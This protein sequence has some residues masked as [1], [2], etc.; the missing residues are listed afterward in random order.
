MTQIEQQ[1][2]NKKK[3]SLVSRLQK[4]SS[5]VPK[6]FCTQN[7][8]NC[9]VQN[10]QDRKY[11]INYECLRLEQEIGLR[12][13]EPTEV[14]GSYLRT[15]LV[16]GCSKQDEMGYTC[17]RNC[18]IAGKNKESFGQ[19]IRRKSFILETKIQIDNNNNCATCTDSFV[20]INLV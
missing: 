7:R 13:D 6:K 19:K 18:Q 15:G 20:E 5:T 16:L 11:C 3:H 9:K 10:F 17:S 1:N 8:K 12:R 4:R 2:R 14:W